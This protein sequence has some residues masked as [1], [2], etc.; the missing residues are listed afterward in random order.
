MRALKLNFFDTTTTA[1]SGTARRDAIRRV[2]DPQFTE[3]HRAF[4]YDYFDNP[5]LGVGYG[6]YTYDGRFAEPVKQVIAHYGLKPGDTIL[7]LGCAKGF[8]LVEFLRQGMSVTGI[9]RSEYALANA[10][11]DVRPYLQ[12]GDFRTL[13]FSDASFDLVLAK[14]TLEHNP[15]PAMRS[16]VMECMRVAKGPILFQICVGRTPG[17]I[18]AMPKWDQS[19]TVNH[20]PEWWDAFFQEIWFRGD[21]HYKI[22]LREEENVS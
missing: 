19:Y 2:G 22:L 7:E 11:P 17:E 21:V 3:S 8:I 10:H 16:A 20:T 18:A 1:R 9:D 6:G 4:G 5:A 12:A 13:P 15:E 14:D